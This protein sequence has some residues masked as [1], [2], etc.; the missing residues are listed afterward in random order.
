MKSKLFAILMLPFMLIYTIPAAAEETKPESREWRDENIY[1]LMVD[2]FK[3]GDT[4]NDYKVNVKD[5]KS[6]NGGD[7]TGIIQELDYIKDMGFTSIWLTPVFD[8]D[9]KGYHGYWIRDFYKTEE[10]F[11]TMKEFKKLVKEAHKRDMKVILDFVVNHT[12]PKHP[13]VKDPSKKD[14]FHDQKPIQNWNNQSEVENNWLY[15]LP[16]LNQENPET[17]KYL[18]EA[19]KW[20]IKET[21]IDGYRLDTVRHVPADFWADFSKAVKS[22]KKN[23]YLL[24]EVWE[25]DPGKIARYQ[26]SGIDGFVDFPQNEYLRKIFASSD[27]SLTGAFLS[28]K[29]NKE[30]FKQPELLGTFMDNHDMPRFTSEIVRNKQNPGTRW[31]LALSYLYTAPGIPIVY[32]GSEIALNGGNDPDNRRLMG[33]KAEKEIIDYLTKLGELRNKYKVLT[34]GTMEVLYDKGGMAVYKRQYKKDTFVVAINNSSKSRTIVLNKED[35]DKNKELRGLL[36]GDLVRSKGDTYKII[37]DR[38]KTEIYALADKTGLN[39][40]YLLLMG[41]VYAAF[42]GFVFLLVKRSRKKNK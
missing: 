34:R 42:I 17:R 13:W 7:F 18:L 29:R 5:P 33:F 25:N 4:Q 14:W 36:E 38:E 21:N 37:L 24:G 15:D 41:T 27:R 39:I 26:E 3:N 20:W 35:L 30:N 40:P 23:F 8:N 9:E 28:I 10:H 31:K 12:G 19:A 32:Y 16:D 1:F 22:E 11:G 2:R 6:Y